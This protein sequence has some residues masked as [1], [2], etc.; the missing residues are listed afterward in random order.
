MQAFT[1]EF[2]LD[3]AETRRAFPSRHPL[4][5]RTKRLGFA[6]PWVRKKRSFIRDIRT[7][8]PCGGGGD[9]KGFVGGRQGVGVGG[10]RRGRD[11][12]LSCIDPRLQGWKTRQG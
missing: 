9:A 6:G 4:D 12:K 7:S 1:K 5:G 2:D 10:A 8:L 11:W 3:E